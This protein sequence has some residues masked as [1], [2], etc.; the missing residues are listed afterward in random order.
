MIMLS[1][2]G[3]FTPAAGAE[4]GFL[5]FSPSADGI[6][7]S[8]EYGD[9]LT[10]LTGGESVEISA[11]MPD[12]E[13]DAV[14]ILVAAVYSS[15][16]RLLDLWGFT[17]SAGIGGV[18]ASLELPENAAGGRLKCFTSAARARRSARTRRWAERRINRRLIDRL[19]ALRAEPE[20]RRSSEPR[21]FI[22]KCRN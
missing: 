10:E 14:P 1:N 13:D 9:A 8:D 22:A 11:Y 12:I 15:E 19:F 20:K 2:G 6:T 5:A 18:S 16:G 4:T 7:V 21:G 17:G 3:S